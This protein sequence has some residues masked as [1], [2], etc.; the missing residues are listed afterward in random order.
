MVRGKRKT[1]QLCSAASQQRQYILRLRRFIARRGH[2]QNMYIDN[3]TNFVGV[4]N[5]LVGLSESIYA[6]QA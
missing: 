6:K 3:P 2:C 4:K 1:T 5:D